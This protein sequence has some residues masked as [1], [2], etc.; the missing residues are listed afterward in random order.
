MMDLPWKATALTSTEKRDP[1][2]SVYL[3]AIDFIR[4]GSEQRVM[5]I[6][7]YLPCSFP[8]WP[9]FVSLSCYP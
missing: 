4:R 5:P 7:G 2:I 9:A 6:R 1:G 8:A 3:K